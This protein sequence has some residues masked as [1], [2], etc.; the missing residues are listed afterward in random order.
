MTSP[1]E[2][3]YVSP[4]MA[5]PAAVF[6]TASLR[7]VSIAVQQ[8]TGLAEP[9]PAKTTS[10]PEL[11][12]KHLWIVVMYNVCISKNDKY[13]PGSHGSPL[14]GIIYGFNTTSSFPKYWEREDLSDL[15]KVKHTPTS[16]L[17]LPAHMFLIFLPINLVP[18]FG[19][20]RTFPPGPGPLPGWPLWPPC[21][22]APPTPDSATAPPC[23]TTPPGPARSRPSTAGP[24]SSDGKFWN[25]WFSIM[26]RIVAITITVVQ[27]YNSINLFFLRIEHD[28][29]LI[30]PFK[31]LM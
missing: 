4:Q 6:A 19:E 24:W 5:E 31:T 2:L 23:P 1:N 12:R 10:H 7:W 8:R 11:P 15:K 30:K 21:T 26:G 14:R 27:I 22:T 20:L 16:K 3:P 29:T 25:L 9:R 28:E 13:V 17:Q 18:M